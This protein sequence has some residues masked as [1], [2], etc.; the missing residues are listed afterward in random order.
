MK[1][2]FVLL[3]LLCGVCAAADEKLVSI[4]DGKTLDGWKVCQGYAPYRVEKGAIAGTTAK[5]SPNSFLCTT[6]EYGDFILEFDTMT[7]PELKVC[8]ARAGA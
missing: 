7:D 5:G 1:R 4:F 8:V 2:Y 3:A 6:R